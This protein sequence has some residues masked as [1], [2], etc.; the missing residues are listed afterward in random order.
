MQAIR[1][2]RLF[3]GDQ[4]VLTGD[5]TVIVD[6]G[7]IVSV[8][9]GAAVP[10]EAD[11]VDLG[12]A[13]L[14]PGLIDAHVHLAFDAGADPV[15][16][17]AARDDAEVLEG[18]RAAAR[19][20]LAAGVTTIRD[21]GD[22]GYLALVLRE[23]FARAPAVGPHVLAAGPP[24]TTPLGHCWYLGGEAEGVEGVRAE[25]RAHAERGVD[26]IKIMAS[27]G[28]LT[29]GTRSHRSQ[30][31]LDEL[32]AA[33][34]EA[35]RL[36]LPITAHAHAGQAIA[37]AVEAGVDSIE[38][39]TFLTE[40]GVEPLPEVIEAIARAG[41]VVSLTLGTRPGSTPPPRIAA[42]MA[43]MIDLFALLRKAGVPIVCGTD[44]G[45]GPPKPH[46][47]L[48]HA[49]GALVSM[50]GWSPAEAL[51]TVTSLAAG[52]CRLEHRK[53]RLAPGMDADILAVAGDPFADPAAL[54]DVRA[55]FRQGHRVR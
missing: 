14:L 51:R 28:E 9:H 38:H 11:L 35:H 24:I 27:G 40:D 37:D 10:A 21:L 55:V 52:V 43:A 31:G 22:R 30:Y 4:T 12:D 5:P 13:T 16:G 41:V 54:L 36:G 18:M 26:V 25:V 1:A 3:D 39:C 44:A 34:A 45:I 42:R 53:G 15:G 48:P 29:P 8:R 17:L 49:V 2:A 6:A 19:T 32:R 23:E 20:A 47:V 50:L 46:D 33:V 7:R